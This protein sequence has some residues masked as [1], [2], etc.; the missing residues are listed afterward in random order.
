MVEA[1]HHR[2]PD[3][4]GD[5]AAGPVH[6]GMARL[7]ILDTSVAGHQPMRNAAGTVCIVYNG[8]M[9]NFVEER[10]ALQARGERFVSGSDTEVVLRLYEVYGDEFLKR[11]RG[12]FAL[13]IYDKRGGP[14]RERLLLAR[15]QLGIKP[16]LYAS[17]GSSWVFAS[18][19]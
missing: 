2:G 6:L 12:M 4:S 19:M 17:V 13:G 7:S 8:E 11:L 3:D 14:G 18:E 15:D 1:M 5:V 9:Y 10:E 16:L